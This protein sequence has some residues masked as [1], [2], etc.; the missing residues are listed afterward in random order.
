MCNIPIKIQNRQ[1]QK[2]IWPSQ[3]V[4]GSYIKIP[5]QLYLT[6]NSY[7]WRLWFQSLGGIFVV[8]ALMTLNIYDISTSFQN[9]NFT[10]C[11]AVNKSKQ[12]QHPKNSIVSSNKSSCSDDGLLYIRG[13][14]A[15]FFRFSLIP[16]HYGAYPRHLTSIS[17]DWPSLVESLEIP[18]LPASLHGH[19]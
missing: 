10:Q 18:P 16:R 17:K 7:R 19:Q 9:Q 8:E 11:N 5:K 4:E 12:M 13:S 15:H 14:S 6:P 1:D 3:Y 2:L